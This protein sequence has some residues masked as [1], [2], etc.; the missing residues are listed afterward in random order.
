MERKGNSGSKRPR[1]PT[2]LTGPRGPGPLVAD[3]R[4][5]RKSVQTA[6]LS[7]AFGP[8]HFPGLL[9]F[10]DFTGRGHGVMATVTAQEDTRLRPPPRGLRAA[11][12]GCRPARHF[13]AGLGLPGNPELQGQ[14]TT[15]ARQ[16]EA[17]TQS[18]RA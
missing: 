12:G 11:H 4:N 15:S 8:L 2:K 3:R 17:S 1:L 18:G 16:V 5:G 10:Q 7:P 6:C 13:T 14:A 9:L